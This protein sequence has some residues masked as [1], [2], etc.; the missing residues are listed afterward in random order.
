M[1]GHSKRRS[2]VAIT[3]SFCV[4]SFASVPSVVNDFW[5]TMRV[6]AFRD[7]MIKDHHDQVL[8]GSFL[9]LDR[10]VEDSWDTMSYEIIRVSQTI[11][12]S[13]DVEGAGY[14]WE[15]MK[16]IGQVKYEE[17]YMVDTGKGMGCRNYDSFPCIDDDGEEQSHQ[18]GLKRHAM[19]F[20]GFA[21]GR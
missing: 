20:D 6:C 13:L 4:C 9:H 3:A 7:C 14:E 11:R 10:L 16:V 18:D 8:I 19:I 12:K 5:S 1:Q 15:D 17:N 21:L 2:G